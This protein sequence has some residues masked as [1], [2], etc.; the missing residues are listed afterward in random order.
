MTDLV[1]ITDMP[2]APVPVD[3]PTARWMVT[4]D[5]EGAFTIRHIAAWIVTAGWDEL[6]PAVFE[7]ETGRIAP[8]RF[9]EKCTH[10]SV[11]A[12]R[13]EAADQVKRMR[14]GRWRR[15]LPALLR[16]IAALPADD[17][18]PGVLANR[19]AVHDG[20]AAA[21]GGPGFG[22]HRLLVEER[23]I[24]EGRAETTSHS[25]IPGGGGMEMVTVPAQ[26]C[27]L[28]A[29]GRTLAGIDTD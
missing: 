15:G 17:R 29:T 16:E 4:Q 24:T 5:A 28:T 20:D 22:A 26:P 11:H 19:L 21:V 2:V 1:E 9:T 8:L 12:T 10:R 13:D 25:P 3:L 18:L 23:L 14:A 27:D 6:L 7:P